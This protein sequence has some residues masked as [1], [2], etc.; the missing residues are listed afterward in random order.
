MGYWLSAIGC[1][2]TVFQALDQF[3]SGPNTIHGSHFHI[4]EATCQGYTADNILGQI[5]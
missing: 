3:Q 5:G 1:L 4:D 2:G